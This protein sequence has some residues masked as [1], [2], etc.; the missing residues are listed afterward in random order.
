MIYPVCRLF[1]ILSCRCC[2][3]IFLFI[4]SAA[5]AASAQESDSHALVISGSPSLLPL[6]AAW[7]EDFRR[8]HRDVQ[9][10]VQ[11]TS[12][13]EAAAALAD[14]AVQLAAMSRA[15]SPAEL[16]AFR[17]R[18]GTTPMPARVALDAVVVIVNAV[19]PLQGLTSAQ[20]DG[21][22]SAQRLCKG[23]GEIR[24]WGQVLPAAI[25][26]TRPIRLFGLGGGMA[27]TSQAVRENLLCGGEFSPSLSQLPEPRALFE[28]V[29]D[30]ANAI[31]FLPSPFLAEGVRPVPLAVGAG[32]RPVGPEAANI[33]SGAYPL[34]RFLYLYMAFSR[35]RLALPRSFVALALSQQGQKRAAEA[36][37]VALPATV[38]SQEMAKVGSAPN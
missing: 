11:S 1:R 4:V 15:M 8:Q 24:L 38:A 35:E 37:F 18:R 27:S 36:G 7:T 21:I 14:G 5:P 6:L 29:R 16:A 10:R 25:W 20:V 22:F 30:H 17:T 33:V 28:A 9:V 26:H 32:G 31:G 19:N 12:D 23:S 13:A 2:I 3:P 34:S